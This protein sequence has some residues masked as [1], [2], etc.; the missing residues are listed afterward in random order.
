MLMV[1]LSPFDPGLLLVILCIWK[2]DIFIANKCAAKGS[3]TLIRAS[4]PRQPRPRPPCLTRSPEDWAQPLVAIVDSTWKK[5][6]KGS[7]APNERQT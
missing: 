5:A 7:G 2:C 1:C 6:T 3:G 4:Y